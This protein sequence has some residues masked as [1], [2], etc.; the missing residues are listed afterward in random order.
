MRY[1]FLGE[2]AT[3]EA[4]TYFPPAVKNYW[5]LG[6]R[7]IELEVTLWFFNLCGS[8][9]G[10]SCFY[11]IVQL[12][13]KE[14][15]VYRMY[16]VCGNENKLGER[17][18]SNVREKMLLKNRSNRKFPFPCCWSLGAE[19]LQKKWHRHFLAMAHVLICDQ[20]GLCC[21]LLLC[22]VCRCSVLCVVALFCD[23]EAPAHGLCFT[24]PPHRDLFQY[25]NN[26][27]FFFNLLNDNYAAGGCLAG[28]ILS[29]H[30]E[31]L[32]YNA[33]NTL[34]KHRGNA[35]TNEREMKKRIHWI[36]RV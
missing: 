28:A 8:Q 6:R 3:N 2:W 9:K 29:C 15:I 22:D 32:K 36:T 5:K 34:K 21:V 12:V 24:K 23:S 19:N 14:S 31:L 25:Q 30:V 7:R 27:K 16:G 35:K 20:I 1:L 18:R 13:H 11:E 26:S 33:R 10:F 4:M 17:R